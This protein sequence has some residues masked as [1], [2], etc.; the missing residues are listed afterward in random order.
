[1]YFSFNLRKAPTTSGKGTVLIKVR[2]FTSDGT[3]KWIDVEV[4]PDPFLGN[5]VTVREENIKPKVFTGT[6][7]SKLIGMIA[8][9]KY[10]ELWGNTSA[11]DKSKK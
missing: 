2:S 8:T 5:E 3:E 4:R 11:V 9:G 7:I 6:D 1:M 10:K